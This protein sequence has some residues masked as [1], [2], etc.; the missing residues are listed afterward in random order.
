MVAHKTGTG[1]DCRNN[2]DVG[3]IFQGEKPLFILTVYTENVPLEMPDVCRDTSSPDITSPD[4]VTR[5]GMHYE[6]RKAKEIKTESTPV[7]FQGPKELFGQA[8]R[9]CTVNKKQ[10]IGLYF[11]FRRNGSGRL[12]GSPGNRKA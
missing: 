12:C 2:N 4:S 11:L 3:I 1:Q 9:H 6:R 5:A 8:I 10:T 7:L